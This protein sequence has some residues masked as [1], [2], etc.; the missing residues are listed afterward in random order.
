MKR[1]LEDSGPEGPVKRHEGDASQLQDQPETFFDLDHDSHYSTTPSAP[2]T[3]SAAPTPT[4]TTSAI[5]SP[6]STAT[7]DT[8]ATRRFPSDLKTIKCSYPN[9]PKTFNRPARL[10]AHLRSHTNDRPFKCPFPDCDK[11]YLEEKHLKQHVKGSHTHERSYVCDEPGCGK[12]FV[13]AT[14]LRRHAA[15]HAGKERYRCRGYE[16]CEL[17]FRKHQT[18]QRHVRTEHLGMP[19]YLCQQDGCGAGF[20]SAGA[21]KRHVEREHGELRFWCD[22]CGVPAGGDD[23]EEEGEGERQVV[24]GGGR[25]D[26]NRVGFTTMAL[27]QAHLRR[28]HVNCIFCDVRCGSQAQLDRHVEM[29]HSTTSVQDRKTVACDW[30]GCPKTFTLRKNLNAHVKTAHQG[31]RFVCGEVDTFGT[32]DI[33]DWN[34][35]EEGCGE[36]FI[37]K[38]K[39]E[40]HVRFVHLGRKRP[41]KVYAVGDDHDEDLIA[42]VSGAAEAAKRNIPCSVAG[43]EARFIRHHDLTL[44]LRN[45]HGGEGL[46]FGGGQQPLMGQMVVAAAYGQQEQVMPSSLGGEQQLSSPEGLS[47]VAGSTEAEAEVEVFV[48]PDLQVGEEF[49]FGGAGGDDLHQDA[50]REFEREWADMRRLIDI[51]ALVDEKPAEF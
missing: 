5:P 43:C 44:H 23:G 16:G 24:G 33:S 49:W 35:A 36:G 32:S 20:D 13:T 34:W 30:P 26:G 8:T 21:M 22:E 15:V 2:P 46:L 4:P 45:Q 25:G 27:L 17:S 47:Q 29:Y 9:C 51:D 12:A 41:K 1:K 50:G 19:A 6:P 48:D 38:L 28:E 42:V 7:L 37:S 39:L 11:D 14:R 10:A 3:K 40:E 18:L 31:F